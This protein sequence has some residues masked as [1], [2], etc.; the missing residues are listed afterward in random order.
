[1]CAAADWSG[2][3]ERSILDSR[4]GV[5]AVVGGNHRLS[6]GHRPHNSLW[7]INDRG[8]LVDRYDKRF[9]SYAEIS[10]FYTPGD[11]VCTF[12]VHGFRFGCLVCIEVNFL[13]CGWSNGHSAWT[14]CCSPRSPRIRFS[15][16]SSAAMLL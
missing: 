11:H 13:S 2:S 9:V 5:W 8:E 3:R 7:V 14:A 15:R 6:D 4:V 16:S 10:A 12:E 1:M